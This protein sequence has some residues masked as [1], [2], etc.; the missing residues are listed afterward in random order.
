MSNKQ[1]KSPIL[2]KIRRNDQTVA[3]GCVFTNGKC[4]V[5]WEGKHRS[6]VVWDSLE[7]LKQVNGH[8]GTIF[9]FED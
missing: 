2:F 4:V 9:I 1:L 8:P 3:H 6:I 5:S 7:D